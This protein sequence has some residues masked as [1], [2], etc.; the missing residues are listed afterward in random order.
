MGAPELSELL[1][2]DA[3]R[4]MCES[5]L[6]KKALE[7]TLGHVARVEESLPHDGDVVSGSWPGSDHSFSAP[8]LEDSMQLS[9]S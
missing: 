1:E 7:D 6:L 4:A 3:M 8:L 9:S 5:G 2:I